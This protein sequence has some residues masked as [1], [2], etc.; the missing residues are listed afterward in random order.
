MHSIYTVSKL[1]STNSIKAI[2]HY[3]KSF[4]RHS[5]IGLTVHTT[6]RQVE[7]ETIHSYKKR[8]SSFKQ[9][10]EIKFLD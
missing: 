5:V 8:D 2:K 9:C 1:R 6:V 10:G 4:T 3:M 7:E